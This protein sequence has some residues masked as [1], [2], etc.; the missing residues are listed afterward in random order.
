[1]GD[2][3]MNAARA[4]EQAR[5]LER[6]T[7]EAGERIPMRA[8]I[9]WAG[10]AGNVESQLQSL[11]LTAGTIVAF[12]LRREPLARLGRWLERERVSSW[13]ALLPKAPSSCSARS[14]P[15]TCSTSCGWS[16]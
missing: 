8:G 2:E 3:A 13:F 10:T 7:L 5:N 16:L 4:S 12:D 14:P 11:L 15:G 6:E 1:M 9:L